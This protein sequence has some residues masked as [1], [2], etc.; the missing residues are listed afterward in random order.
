VALSPQGPGSIFPE[1]AW[2]GIAKPVLLITGTRDQA[3]EGGWQ[4]RTSRSATCVGAARRSRS[5]MA[6]RT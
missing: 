6:R 1:T 2:R 4:S 5:S 3:L